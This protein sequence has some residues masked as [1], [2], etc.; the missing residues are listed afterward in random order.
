MKKQ[1]FFALALCVVAVCSCQQDKAQQEPYELQVLAKTDIAD[2]ESLYLTGKVSQQKS[3]AVAKADDLENKLYKITTQ[4]ETKE[5]VFKDAKGND[6]KF[7]VVYMDK[8]SADLIIVVGSVIQ[9]PPANLDYDLPLPSFERYLIRKSDG[10]IFDLGRYGNSILRGVSSMTK[11]KPTL[12]VDGAGDFYCV[13]YDPASIGLYQIKVP[14]N[15]DI[16]AVKISG[17]LEYVGECYIDANGCILMVIYDWINAKEIVC[18]F[19]DG[20]FGKYRTADKSYNLGTQIISPVKNSEGGFVEVKAGEKWNSL[21]IVK[22]IPDATNRVVNYQT[23]ST[24]NTEKW[25]ETAKLYSREASG[26][27]LIR[28][29]D[30][31]NYA[32][33]DENG[34]VE[35]KSYEAGFAYQNQ[36][37]NND[38]VY[39]TEANT[40][41][42]MNLD[43]RELK[44][45]FSDS[46]YRIDKYQV[47]PDDSYIEL[48]GLRYSDA[49][50]VM[51]RV[52]AAGQIIKETVQYNESQEVI[53][54]VRLN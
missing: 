40:L 28:S 37:T 22:A 50:K 10:A 38:Y 8:I 3:V 23:T 7:S 4:G 29:S 51:L 27:I 19:P 24:I 49:K 21:D 43:T 15:G 34:Q 36:T 26:R 12:M 6:V 53:I 9:E 35:L 48:F 52:N 14:T 20:S 33:V 44:Q 17:D 30:Y 5:V 32:F 46:R 1:L 11:E 18:R 39:G 13:L 16:S 41:H 31:K 54:F 42:R 25:G 2:A 47:A 45:I